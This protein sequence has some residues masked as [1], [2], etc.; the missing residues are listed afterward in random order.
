MLRH[1]SHEI[2]YVYQSESG[3]RPR[4]TIKHTRLVKVLV[5][6]SSTGQDI[7]W[8]QRKTIK[9]D[10]LSKYVVIL[11]IL[12]LWLKNQQYITSVQMPTR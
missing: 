7:R 9:R 6:E 2:Y 8:E 12:T 3:L 4:Y 10:H 5:A 11:G 1:C